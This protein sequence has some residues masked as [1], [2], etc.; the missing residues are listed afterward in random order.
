MIKKINST[1]EMLTTVPLVLILYCSLRK[2]MLHLHQNHM[3]PP[4]TQADIVS[5]PWYLVNWPAFNFVYF[6]LFIFFCFVLFYLL[7]FIFIFYFCYLFIYSFFIF[8]FYFYFFFFGGGVKIKMPNQQ[9]RIF[10]CEVTSY[11]QKWKPCSW[12]PVHVLKRNLM[13]ATA[14]ITGTQVTK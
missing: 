4:K 9:F 8:Y 7:L 6:I 1:F 10:L 2:P 3:W 14:Q 13:T 11:L 12:K 5:N